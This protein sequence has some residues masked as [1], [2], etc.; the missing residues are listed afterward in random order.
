MFGGDIGHEERS[1]D[2][3]PADIAAGEE[4]FGGVAA[5]FCKINAD[6]EDKKEV[7][8]DDSEIKG[9]EGAMGNSGSRIHVM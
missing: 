3:E 4:I 6:G 9:G 1:A 2:G 5:L 8:A 7:N